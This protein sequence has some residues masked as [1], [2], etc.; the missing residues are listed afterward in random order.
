MFSYL[1][2]H[3]RISLRIS[4]SSP[5]DP[6]AK[7]DQKSVIE[8]AKIVIELQTHH[9]TL[10]I[11]LE[12]CM[13]VV[14]PNLCQLVGSAIAS[15][16]IAAAGGVDKLASMPACNIQVMGGS[17]SAQIGFSQMERNHTG[18]FSQMDVVRDAP[19]KFQMQLVRM[20]ATN[21]AKCARVDYLGTNSTQ[22]AKL[23]D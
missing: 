5:R 9:E 4:I 11:Y 2:P 17:R 6:L 22:G 13:Q 23:R 19:K 3:Q 18:I 21:T 20:L 15:K 12:T 1:S 16:L 14:A 7:E 10:M 8:A